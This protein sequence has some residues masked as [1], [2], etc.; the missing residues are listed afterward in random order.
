MNIIQ[1]APGA[2]DAPSAAAYVGL[3]E[4]NMQDKVQAGTF[5]PSR[6]ISARRVVW[7]RAE[8]D[9]Y[10]LSLPVSNLSPGPGRRAPQAGQ[11]AA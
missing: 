5:P 4:R 8:L 9:A 1:T 7:L 6:L 2:L 10:L 3:S 11:S